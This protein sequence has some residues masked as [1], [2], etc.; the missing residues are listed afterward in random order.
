M[1]LCKTLLA[2]VVIL[3]SKNKP[4]WAHHAFASEYDESK[5]V[6]ISGKLSE[7][8]WTNPH[9]WMDFGAKG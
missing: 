8:K 1:K 9:V 7:F 6:T 5:R 4:T 2:I 3:L